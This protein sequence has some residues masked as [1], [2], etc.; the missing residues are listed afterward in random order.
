MAR[1]HDIISRG[2]YDPD[3]VIAT[4]YTR[5]WTVESP[6]SALAQKLFWFLIDQAGAGVTEDVWHTVSIAH[7]CRDIGMRHMTVP[8]LHRTCR[9]LLR[10]IYCFSR[11]DADTHTIDTDEGNLVSRIQTHIPM[12]ANNRPTGQAVIRWKFDDLFRDIARTSEFW[13][14]I[15][16]SIINNLRSRY[17][18]SLYPYLAAYFSL[19]PTERGA[20][21]VEVDHLRKILGVPEGRLRQFRDLRTR[22]LEPAVTGINEMSRY[23]LDSQLIK[24]GRVV[25]KVR[26]TWTPK[27]PA[28]Q[29]ELPLAT[30]P[31][32]FAVFPASGIVQ[33]TPW[34]TIAR[35]WAPDF[36]PNIVGSAYAAW[37]K[38][39]RIRLAHESN[40]GRFESFCGTYADAHQ[41]HEP[42]T[43]PAWSDDSVHE[44]SPYSEFPADG[45]IRDTSFGKLAATH[46]PGTDADTL[47]HAFA[48]RLRTTGVPFEAP[49]PVTHEN[50]FVAF[51]QAWQR[52][53]TPA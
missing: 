17:A 44:I 21:T 42:A 29:P 38:K 14:L 11:Y 9:E 37:C 20:L 43:S 46:A 5:G 22:A 28:T 53:H 10:I 18:V 26:L 19:R 2:V 25:G 32:P 16:R 41:P 45:S 51:C 47:G 34:E 27:A 50:D 15:D 3:T 52:D 13:T 48:Q 12:H 24:Q 6:P 30:D 4:E 23:A 49:H 7:A 35:D 1:T 36:A 31:D 40:R 8:E 39:R 33:G